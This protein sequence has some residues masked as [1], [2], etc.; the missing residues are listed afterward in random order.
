MNQNLKTMEN[1]RM[2]HLR[3][4]V[5]NEVYPMDLGMKILE[6]T[7]SVKAGTIYQIDTLFDEEYG[8]VTVVIYYY[9]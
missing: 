3:V 6:F 9:Q 7:E 8:R 5:I 4:H 2:N 1:L